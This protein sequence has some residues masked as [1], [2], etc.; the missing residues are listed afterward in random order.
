M[1]AIIKFF[2]KNKKNRIWP[3][4]FENPDTVF[5]SEVCN[6]CLDNFTDTDKISLLCGHQFHYSC[7][8]QWFN[9]KTECPCC[10]QSFTWLKNGI[11]IK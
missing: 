8:I 4:I 6:I 7:I 3:V 10:R 9:K 5:P 11:K 2:R 1:S